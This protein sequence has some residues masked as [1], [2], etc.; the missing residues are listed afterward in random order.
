VRLTTRAPDGVPRPVVLV[1]GLF[2]PA[3]TVAQGDELE[4]TLLNNLP[5]AWPQAGGG[6]SVHLHGFSMAGGR[7]AWFDGTA[8]VATCPVSPGGGRSAVP[9]PKKQPR[10]RFSRVLVSLRSLVSFTTMETPSTSLAFE[11]LGGLPPL[12]SRNKGRRR[13]ISRQAGDHRSSVPWSAPHPDVN[14]VLI[15]V[16]TCC[17]FL[18][19]ARVTREQF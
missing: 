5:A 10:R 16:R 3:L 13:T 2:Q 18:P 11:P 17:R 9:R 1:N 12:P 8:Q 15:Q 7:A 19:G 14:E 4:L 6:V